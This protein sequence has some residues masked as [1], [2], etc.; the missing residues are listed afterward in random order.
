MDI[1]VKNEEVQVPKAQ[2]LRHHQREEWQGEIDSMESMLPSLKT[3]QDRG[4]VN[5][6]MKRLKEGLH[7]QSPQELDG[8]AKNKIYKASKQ[9][10]DKIRQGMLSREEMRK[11]PA[12][13]VGQ[14]MRHEKANKKE[15][16]AWKNMQIMLDPTSNDPDLANIERIRPNGAQDRLRTDAQITGH[17]TYQNIPDEKW[18]MA[19]EGKKPENTALAQ[20]KKV[21]KEMSEDRKQQLREALAK[22]RAARQNKNQ[23]RDVPSQI[24]EGE[25]VPESEA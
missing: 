25:A 6:R 11:N 24:Q 18:D 16:L 19:F 14:F 13:S 2:L 8:A 15:I 12:G 21:R 1:A 17:M 22:A 20:V 5:K 9:L 10:E 23:D 3:P 7:K 4:E